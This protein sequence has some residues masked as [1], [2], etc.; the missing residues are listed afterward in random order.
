MEFTT[1]EEPFAYVPSPAEVEAE[2]AYWQALDAAADYAEWVAL[3]AEREAEELDLEAADEPDPPIPT[4]QCPSAYDG[5]TK[6]QRAALYLPDNYAVERVDAQRFRVTNR[7]NG[8]SFALFQPYGLRDTFSV[9]SN[10]GHRYLVHRDTCE[11]P[12]AASRAREGQR[13]CKH[14]AVALAVSR[15]LKRERQESQAPPVAEEIPT[16][17]RRVA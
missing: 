13:P 4:A 11:C 10:T 5:L 8:A 14:A 2:R 7:V 3:Q 15:S 6:T 17:S 1:W 12:D 16:P 9:F